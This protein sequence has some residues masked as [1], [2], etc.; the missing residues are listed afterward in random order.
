[1]KPAAVPSPNRDKI[2]DFIVQFKREH[3]GN[4]PSIREIMDACGLH[5]TSYVASTLDKLVADGRL[6]IGRH[7]NDFRMIFVIGGAWEIVQNPEAQ[8]QAQ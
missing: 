5:S 2:F 3:D 6:M 1:M 4:S 8:N 7:K